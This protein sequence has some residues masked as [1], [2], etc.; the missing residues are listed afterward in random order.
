MVVPPTFSDLGKVAKDVFNKGFSVGSTKLNIK[1]KTSSNV[2]LN[3]TFEVKNDQLITSFETSGSP[4]DGVTL[5]EKWTS[6]NVIKANIVGEDILAKGLKI[7]LE[8]VVNPSSSKKAATVKTGYKTDCFNGALDADLN[9]AGPTFVASTVTAYNGFQGG[10]EVGFD[11]EKSKMT[12]NSLALG[13][14][15]NDL[16]IVSFLRD[17]SV[18]DSYVH[19]KVNDK[20]QVAA[21]INWNNQSHAAAFDFGVKHQLDNVTSVAAKI[22]GAGKTTLS[23]THKLKSWLDV[24]LSSQLNAKSLNGV[25][26]GLSF[27]VNL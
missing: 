11:T 25:T 19:H 27:E 26:N 24:T 22:D 8:V 2:S 20:T 15:V 6:D 18:F 4:I 16:T 12:K 5:K 17:L 1:S 21:H 13:Y 3:P 7:D 10:A 14:A 23:C 9:L